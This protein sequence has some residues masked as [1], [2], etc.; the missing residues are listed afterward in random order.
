MRTIEDR[1]WSIGMK[2][3]DRERTLRGLENR[4]QYQAVA[5]I[6]AP[7]ARFCVCFCGTD[8]PSPVS[9]VAEQAGEAGRTIEPGPAQPI[10]GAVAAH[11]SRGGAVADQTV[12][13][14]VRRAVRVR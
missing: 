11:E 14:D 10:D 3:D 12:I 9:F 2:V 7:G 1:A 5:D 8:P 13:L 4:F 6:G